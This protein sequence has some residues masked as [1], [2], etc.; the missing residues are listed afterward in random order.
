M[1]VPPPAA[2]APLRCSHRL[3]WSAR[4]DFTKIVTIWF[5][6]WP[7]R[8][9]RWFH[10]YLGLTPCIPALRFPATVYPLTV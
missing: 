1:G 10:E 5:A 9:A 7:A 4:T 3:I 8:P 2:G 6:A